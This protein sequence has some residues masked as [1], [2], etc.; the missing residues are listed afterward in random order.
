MTHYRVLDYFDSYSRVELK[1]ITGRTHQIRVHCA[2][3]GHPLLG[4]TTYNSNPLKTPLERH[5]LHAYA[6]SFTFDG[7][8]FSFQ[9]PLP[10]DMQ[11]L[12]STPF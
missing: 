9:S 5:A 7:T 6:L 10:A 11:A 2:A 8:S 4:D 3:I 12:I 1:P